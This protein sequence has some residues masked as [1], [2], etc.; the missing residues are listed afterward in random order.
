MLTDLDALILTIWGEAQGEPIEGQ[1]AVG[2]VIRNRV[3]HGKSFADVCLAPKQFSCWEENSHMGD[4][5]EHLM[6]GKPD[7]ILKQAQW[8]A[9]GI[10][11]NVVLDNTKGATHYYADYIPA[12][13]WAQHVPVLAKIGRHIFLKTL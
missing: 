7:A 8:V 10:I 3:T 2:C 13:T 12:P 5:L 6:S 11:N 1:I 4:A 9:Q